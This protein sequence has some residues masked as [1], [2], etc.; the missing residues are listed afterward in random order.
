MGRLDR[1]PIA[2]AQKVEDRHL[3]GMDVG[4]SEGPEPFLPSC[5]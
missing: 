3:A 5:L 1:E 2:V 4:R